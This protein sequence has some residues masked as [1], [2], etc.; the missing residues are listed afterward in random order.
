[1]CQYLVSTKAS[2]L[3]NSYYVVGATYRGR[4]ADVWALGVTLYCMIMGKYP[5]IGDTLQST[6]D[7]IVH[8]SLKLSEGL[9]PHLASLLEGLLCKDP[10]NRMTLDEVVQHWFYMDSS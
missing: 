2:S 3:I 9:N 8:G 10:I 5:F 1:M 4:A 7:E 6:Y